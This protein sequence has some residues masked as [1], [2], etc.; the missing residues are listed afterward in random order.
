MTMALSTL[1]QTSGDWAVKPRA[2]GT[3]ILA[4]RTLKRD[5]GRRS[6]IQVMNVSEE[7][8]GKG[9]GRLRLTRGQPI[10]KLLLL[11]EEPS[12][13]KYSASV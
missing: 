6:A 1:R 2:L 10:R 8:F 5:E 7:D 3:A 11:G 4:A 12:C 9:V 13:L